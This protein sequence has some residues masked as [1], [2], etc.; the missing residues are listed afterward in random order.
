[1]APLVGVINT[2]VLPCRPAVEEQHNNR[3]AFGSHLFWGHY[4][5]ITTLYIYIFWSITALNVFSCADCMLHNSCAIKSSL[6]APCHSKVFTPL[7]GQHTNT[8]A[9]RIRRQTDGFWLAGLGRSDSSASDRAVLLIGQPL[10]IQ[11]H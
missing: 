4:M 9:G 11:F 3:F 10:K 6:L 5:A 1:M 7:H 2:F 8:W